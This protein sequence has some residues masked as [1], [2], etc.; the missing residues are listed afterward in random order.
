MDLTKLAMLK[1]SA[2]AL[3]GMLFLTDT[4]VTAQNLPTRDELAAI[5]QA[6]LTNQTKLS[7]Y[8]WQETQFVSVNGER[9]DYRLYSVRID[10]NG[11]YRRNLVTEHT[12]QE[13][14]FEPKIKE[15]LSP[16]GPY[17][18]QLWELVNQYTS[19]NSE[20]LTRANS[21]G[22]IVLLREG[23]LI[24][25]AIKNYS[26]PGDSVAMTVNQRTRQILTVQTRSYLTDP[27]DTV[28]IQAEFAE[29]PDGTNHVATTEID[30]VSRNITV[31]LTNW[32]YQ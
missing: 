15:Q 30:S 5:G 14:T 2:V 18:Q 17:A 13:A 16:C 1:L 32:S 20:R 3:F 12:G 31:K 4:V 7:R 26:K 28:T 21:R 6:Q 19:L 24:K 11:Q 27:Q 8:T 25:L 29:L 23:D 22:E 10:A 9:V